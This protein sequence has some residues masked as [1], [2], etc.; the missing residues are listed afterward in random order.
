MINHNYTKGRKFHIK[1][2][3]NTLFVKTNILNAIL[4]KGIITSLV[5][6]ATNEEFIVHRDGKRSSAIQLRYQNEIVDLN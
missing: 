1:I 5:C 6:K 2:S 4:E 3:D